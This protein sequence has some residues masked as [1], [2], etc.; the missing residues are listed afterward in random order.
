MR[1]LDLPAGTSARLHILP[2]TPDFPFAVMVAAPGVP[3]TPDAFLARLGVPGEVAAILTHDRDVTWPSASGVQILDMT[4]Q[5]GGV[6]M[7]GFVSIADAMACIQKAR[8]L[9]A[10]GAA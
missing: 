8:G 1:V 9:G 2:D 4:L 6:A 7:L 5:K 3:A 10:G